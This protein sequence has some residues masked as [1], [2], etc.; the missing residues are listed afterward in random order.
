MDQLLA[1][2]AAHGWL[3]VTAIAF[4]CGV[5]IGLYAVYLLERNRELEA[6]LKKTKKRLKAIKELSQPQQTVISRP[7]QLA[8]NFMKSY[9]LN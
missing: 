4:V 8:T 3:I 5:A 6:Q 9:R 7:K 2:L 1:L